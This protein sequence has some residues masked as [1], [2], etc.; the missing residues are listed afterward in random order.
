M[1]ITLVSNIDKEEFKKTKSLLESK[2]YTGEIKNNALPNIP[3]P[4]MRENPKTET[5]FLKDKMQSDV[6][7]SHTGALKRTDPDFYKVNLANYILGGSSLSSRLSKKVRDANG[8]TYTIYSYVSATHGKGEFAIYFGSNNKNVNKALELTKE[9]F[10][11]FTKNGITANELERAKR[12]LIDSFISRN[13]ATYKNISNTLTGVEFYNLGK[14]YI[15][16][17]PKI[18][19]SI[20]VSDINSAIKKYFHPD[21]LNIVISG[22]YKKS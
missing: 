6:Y 20:K 8:L 7:L 16:N 22:E 13:W 12:S 11:K 17:Y 4:I 9:E 1:I 19:N 15:T 14:D 18:I 5:I 21:K 3:D 2:I 10:E